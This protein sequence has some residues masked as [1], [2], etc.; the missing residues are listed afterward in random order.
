[1]FLIGSCSKTRGPDPALINPHHIII[2]I[3]IRFTR[4]IPSLRDGGAG[5]GAGAQTSPSFG[6]CSEIHASSASVVPSSHVPYRCVFCSECGRLFCL[7]VSPVSSSAPLHL[8]A[9]LG[10]DAAI[11]HKLMD[12]QARAVTAQTCYSTCRNVR[13]EMVPQSFFFSF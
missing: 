4:I 12:I 2:A 1:M 5:A 3:F 13:G 11:W 6:L 7:H 10:K 9:V 8:P